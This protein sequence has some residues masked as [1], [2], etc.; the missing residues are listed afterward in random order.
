MDEEK[1]RIIGNEIPEDIEDTAE[2]EKIPDANS[3]IEPESLIEAEP[4]VS[5]EAVSEAPT[6]PWERRKYVPP[7]QEERPIRQT[8]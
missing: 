8:E 2:F 7:A 4:E 1:D 5:E 6:A 3:E